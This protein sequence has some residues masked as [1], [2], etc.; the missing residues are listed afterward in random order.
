M[1]GAEYVVNYDGIEDIEEEEEFVE[2]D[3][4]EQQRQLIELVKA[5]P[6]LWD[7]RQRGYCNKNF[8]KELAWATVASMIGDM[9]RNNIYVIQGA[10]GILG[11]FS[12]VEIE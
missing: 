2:I 1:S 8:N 7:K 10:T 3:V 11:F 6:P 9:T 4:L 5:N 12:A